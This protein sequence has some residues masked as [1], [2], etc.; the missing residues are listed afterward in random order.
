MQSNDQLSD[1]STDQC[2]NKCKFFVKK[3]HQ[4]RNIRQTRRHKSGD[5]SSEDESVVVNSGRKSASNGLIQS[6]N[7]FN[8]LKR[9]LGS[10]VDEANQS[11]EDG[12]KAD[13]LHVVYS[14]NRSSQR[15]GPEDMGATA[16]IETETDKAVDAQSIFE[17]AQQINERLKGKEDDRIYRGLNNYIQ[18]RTKKDTPQG[19]ASS[20]FVRKGPIRAPENIRSTVRWDY[21]P[22]LCKDYKET[23]FCGFGESCIFLHDR[24]DYKSGWQLELEAQQ[25]KDHVEDP[26]QYLIK[27]DDDLPFKCFICR[28]SFE[29]PVVTKCKH[30]FCEKCAIDQFKKSSKCYVCGQQTGGVFNIA[31]EIIK[32]LSQ[33]ETE[34]ANSNAR[35][36]DDIPD[37]DH[38]DDSDCDQ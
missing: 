25:S 31:K 9:K 16:I 15:E 13:S 7:S 11:D 17:K 19:N 4:K 23:G 27:E 3:S 14:S 12:N 2:S 29:S 22:D 24:T 5:E 6:T 1:R 37:E 28:Q 10:E 8:K 21:Q 36:V 34:D 20:G 26:D 32:K 18:Y 35:P 30:Y 38:S 33:T